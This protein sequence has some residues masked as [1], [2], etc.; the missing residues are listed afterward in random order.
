MALYYNSTH[1]SPLCDIRVNLLHSIAVVYT[2]GF[3]Q[4]WQN[5]LQHATYPVVQSRQMLP[6]LTP[7]L[8]EH[9]FMQAT[10]PLLGDTAGMP[11]LRPQ[12]RLPGAGPKGAGNSR[13]C[14]TM[15]GNRGSTSTPAAPGAGGPQGRPAPNV[16]KSPVWGVRVLVLEALLGLWLLL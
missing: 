13:G 10:P 2:Q 1:P 5:L 7:A 3:G 6:R 14:W 4:N 12:N 16:L 9:L 11:P 8:K 15:Q